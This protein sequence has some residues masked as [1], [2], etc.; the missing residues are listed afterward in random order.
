MRVLW[1]TA[2]P[3]D[4]AGGGGNIRQAHL[5]AAVAAVHETHL[6]LAGELADGDVRDRLASVAELPVAPPS[7]P[8]STAARRLLDL[9]LAGPEG[10]P[11]RYAG[12]HARAVL[13]PR[14]AEAATTGRYDVVVVQHGGLAALLPRRRSGRWVAELHNVESETL[15]ALAGVAGRGRRR[16]LLRAQARRARQWERWIGSAYDDV[17]AVSAEDAS[18]LACAPHVVPNGVD[19]GAW[20]SSAVPGPPRAMF[21]A[22]LDYLPN[23]DGVEWFAREVWPRVRAAVPD[24]RL[25]V[26]GRRPVDAVTALSGLPGVAVHADV[27]DV[28][29][30]V[31]AARVC[32]VPLRVGSG[33]RLKVLE[34]WAAGRPVVGTT[35][36]LAG[37]GVEDGRNALVADSCEDLADAVVRTLRDGPL[38][39]SLADTGRERARE[40]Y[41]WSA[42]GAAYADWLGG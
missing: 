33:S 20:P 34:A 19:V 8:A 25:D 11:E 23:V 12:R 24:A 14:L 39:Q 41:D 7:V 16:M 30:F 36:G 26:V 22:T 28:R 1:V 18:A 6:L 4:R 31:T 27:P 38:A 5:I 15:D 40:R 42:L 13:G 9:R 37:L 32:V 10:P 21:T 29:P 3:P 17:V 35:V 2:E